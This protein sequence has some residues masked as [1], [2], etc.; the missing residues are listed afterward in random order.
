MNKEREHIRHKVSFILELWDAFS[1]QPISDAALL[2][3]TEDGRR[4]IRKPE[5]F[6]VFTDC[7][8][9]TV[10]TIESARYEREEIRIIEESTQSRILKKRLCPGKNYPIPEGTAC[11]YGTIRPNS[12][13]EVF[14]EENAGLWHLLSDYQV[15]RAPDEM[16]IFNPL[17]KDLVGRRFYIQDREEKNTDF[18][19]VKQQE[20]RSGKVFLAE[21]LKASYK[22]AGTKLYECS[23]ARAD[24]KGRFLIPLK[25]RTQGEEEALCRIWTE[26]R[27]D[28][29][30]IRPGMRLEWKPIE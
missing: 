7:L 10:V 29:A 25:L 18:F 9:P 4:P 23:S 1:D 2:V 30:T 15:K 17:K 16:E 3:Q 21:P 8:L 12:Q 27:S 13:I 26:D 20:G 24:E 22:K 19:E 14:V 5:G 11:L 6:Y 28:K